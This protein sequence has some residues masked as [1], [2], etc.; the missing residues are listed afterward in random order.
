MEIFRIPIQ[1]ITF[2]EILYGINEALQQ[3]KQLRITYLNIH[4]MNQIYENKELFE[5]ILKFEIKYLDGFG[6]SLLGGLSDH[7]PFKRFTGADFIEPLLKFAEEKKLSIGIL[8][9]KPFVSARLKKILYE[10]HPT[11]KISFISHGYRV[12]EVRF[13]KK[14][15][16]RKTDI[17]LLGLGTPLQEKWI[18]KN[19][20]RLK[21][22]S[23]FWS[24]GA[25]F[26]FY[27]GT[28]RRGPDFLT[29]HGFEWLCRLI[30]EPIRL[31]NRYLLG[32]PKFYL[33]VFLETMLKF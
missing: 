19:S 6:L 8:A 5:A 11:L 4:V 9:G 30:D 20:V 33:R 28:S 22:I 29:Q 14:I 25:L 1:N 2:A 27:T 21:N 26:D 32:N 24:V 16:T 15:E 7:K 31:S 10:K 23:V 3:K 12:D 18:I 17:L 13:I